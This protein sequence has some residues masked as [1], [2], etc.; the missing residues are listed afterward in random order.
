MTARSKIKIRLEC[1]FEK[2]LKVKFLRI[3]ESMKVQNIM[4]HHFGVI[5]FIL[6]IDNSKTQMRL[7]P[8]DS[9]LIWNFRV[10][11]YIFWLGLI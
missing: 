8:S 11:D 9:F 5:P 4:D 7:D 10:F 2:S 6:F 3:T 1:K